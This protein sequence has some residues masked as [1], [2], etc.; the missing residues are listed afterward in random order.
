MEI[1]VLLIALCLGFAAAA[2][3]GDNQLIRKPNETEI[4]GF[5]NGEDTD[6]T[7]VL[8][9]CDF[10]KTFTFSCDVTQQGADRLKNKSTSTI[11]GPKQPKFV[12]KNVSGTWS[13]EDGVLKKHYSSVDYLAIVAKCLFRSDYY[14]CFGVPRCDGRG[15]MSDC[16][17]GEPWRGKYEGLPTT[18]FK[19]NVTDIALES[20]AMPQTSVLVPEH[21]N[22]TLIG[23]N[24]AADG[25]SNNKSIPQAGQTVITLTN[26]SGTFTSTSNG[27]SDSSIEVPA[28]G[29]LSIVKVTGT[30]GTNA[31][32]QVSS[33]SSFSSGS[34]LTGS[35]MMGNGSPFPASFPGFGGFGFPTVFRR[36]RPSPAIRNDANDT[37]VASFGSASSSSGSGSSSDTAFSSGSAP[38]DSPQPCSNNQGD[39][40]MNLRCLIQSFQSNLFQNVFSSFQSPRFQQQQ[41][42]PFRSNFNP[43]PPMGLGEF[44]SRGGPTQRQSQ[45]MGGMFQ[46]QAMQQPQGRTFGVPS[47]RFGG[48]GPGFG[49]FKVM[50]VPD[51][52]PSQM[53]GRGNDDNDDDM[54]GWMS[55]FR[56]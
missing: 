12:V 43:P 35:D 6:W 19:A 5:L 24:P 2:G 41:P 46:S 51:N 38:F 22:E 37:G 30:N 54:P 28:N 48:F 29:T 10:F 47:M 20:P 15:A 17:G 33:F 31:G 21:S 11:I 1:T 52:T 36:R 55:S 9:V 53:G 23:A 25:L 3:N 14:E 27:D 7:D 34:A 16:H 49:G 44:S 32:V 45:S 26:S 42:S 39:F 8:Y 56:K 4:F 13:A 50:I 18:G 40:G